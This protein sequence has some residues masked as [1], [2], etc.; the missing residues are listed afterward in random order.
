MNESLAGT[1]KYSIGFATRLASTPAQIVLTDY[2][3]NASGSETID[4]YKGS[5]TSWIAIVRAAGKTPV[6]EG[7][8]PVCAPT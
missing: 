7:P 8:N 6:L 5:L 4:E 2:A 3:I 1:G